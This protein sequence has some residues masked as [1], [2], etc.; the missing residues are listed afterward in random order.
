MLGRLRVSASSPPRWGAKETA[1]AAFASAVATNHSR[2]ELG[3]AATQARAPGKSWGASATLWPHARGRPK[4]RSP[5]RWGYWTVN[6]TGATAM[7]LVSSTSNT[8]STASMIT[9]A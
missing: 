5:K 8:S 9:P 4:T 3:Y 7:L 6:V 2:G 1:P